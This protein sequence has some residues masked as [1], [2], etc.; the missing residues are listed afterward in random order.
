MSELTQLRHSASG[1]GHFLLVSSL[2]VALNVVTGHPEELRTKRLMIA[3]DLLKLLELIEN[4]V[5]KNSY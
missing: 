5:T 4:Q 1:H 3:T 2:S